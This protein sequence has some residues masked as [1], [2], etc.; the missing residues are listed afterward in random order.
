MSPRHAAPRKASRRPLVGPMTARNRHVLA[1]VGGL[2]VASALTVHASTA[3]F[4]AQTANSGNRWAAARVAITHQGSGSALFNA[5]GLVPGSTGS[6]CVV[7]SYTGDT[8]ADVKLFAAVTSTRPG[9]ED[10]LDV[11]VARGTGANADCTDFTSSE[12]LFTG[13]MGGLAD[14][15]TSFLSGLGTWAPSAAPAAPALPPSSTYRISWTV[16]NNDA[17]QGKSADATF[18]WEAQNR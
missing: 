11:T 16:Q 2:A 7:V 8:A 15:H 1:A 6:R 13:T 14:T 17:A 18:T 4:T 9:L 10:Y 3:A 5:T 12:S